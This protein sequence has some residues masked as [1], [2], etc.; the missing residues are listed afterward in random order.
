MFSPIKRRCARGNLLEERKKDRIANQT[1]RAAASRPYSIIVFLRQ[2]E[3]TWIR[4]YGSGAFV[5]LDAGE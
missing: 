2:G 4:P 1:H 3:N 5:H